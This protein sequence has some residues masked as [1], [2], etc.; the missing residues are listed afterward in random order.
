MPTR[1]THVLRVPNSHQF[2]T[3]ILYN[4]TI[5]VRIPKSM[6]SVFLNGLVL[7]NDYFLLT[8]FLS[9][10]KRQANLQYTIHIFGS[11][12]SGVDALIE[13]E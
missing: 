6:S 8:A 2:L 10:N 9:F 4:K 12:A 11:D 1:L 7:V 13:T 5:A 3:S